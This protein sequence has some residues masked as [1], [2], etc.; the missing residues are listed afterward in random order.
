MRTRKREKRAPMD[1]D[2]EDSWTPGSG[3]I[4]QRGA[5]AALRLSFP[6]AILQKEKEKGERRKEHPSQQCSPSQDPHKPGIF[7]STNT[8]SGTQ[9]LTTPKTQLCQLLTTAGRD[10]VNHHPSLHSNLSDFTRRD[11]KRQR[12]TGQGHTMLALSP[13]QQTNTEHQESPCSC[14]VVSLCP[15]P[16]ETSARIPSSVTSPF[17]SAHDVQRMREERDRSNTSR[18]HQATGRLFTSKLQCCQVFLLRGRGE[19]GKPF[20]RHSI[21]QFCDFTRKKRGEKA[22]FVTAIPTQKYLLHRKKEPTHTT[23]C[24]CMTSASPRS[25]QRRAHGAL[26]LSPTLALPC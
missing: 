3:H 21:S 26:H 2:S 8:K 15:Q 25:W 1:T 7:T 18:R 19:S 14:N 12:D 4:Q 20:V 16:G 22:G 24:P 11:G 10:G 23:T 17:R 6:L 9:T 13:H 5:H